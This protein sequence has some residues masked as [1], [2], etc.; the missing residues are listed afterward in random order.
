M[1]RLAKGIVA[2]RWLIV[3]LFLAMIV[4]SVF[5]L[6]WVHVEED[7][8]AYLPVDAEAKVGLTI[9]E[10]EFTT[11]G[12]AKV[13]VE[14]L[15]L[16]EAQAL[17]EQIGA[18]DNVVLVQFDTTEN[19]FHDNTALYDL[20]FSDVAMAESSITALNEVKALLE[21]RE[22]TVYSDVGFSLAAAVAGQMASVLVF[23]VIVVFAVLIFT[24]TTYAEIPLMII[25]FVVAAAINL[26][27]HFLLGTI[28]FVSNS[29]AIVLQLALSVDYAIIL[30][31]RFKEEHQTLGIRESVEKALAASI[32]EIFASSLTTIAGLTAM[33]FM[34]FRL[35]LDLGLGLI[36]AIFCS[37]FTVFLFMPSMLMLFGK[38]IDKTKHKSFVPKI[39]FVGKFAYATRFIM[40][41]LFVALVAGSYMIFSRTE[42]VYAQDM[43]PAHRMTER[44]TSNARIREAFGTSNLVALIV[45]AGDYTSEQALTQELSEYPEVKSATGLASFEIA[46]G[47]RL[48]DAVT[49]KELSELADVDETAAEAVFAFYAANAG[50]HRAALE[51]LESYRAPLVDVFLFLYKQ[52]QNGNAD[53]LNEDQIQMIEDLYGQLSLLSVQLQSDTYSRIVLDLNLPTQSDETFAFLDKIHQVAAPYYGDQVVLTGEPVSALGFKDSFASDNRVVSLMSLVLGLII[54][55]FTFRSFGMPLLLNLVIQG[56]IWMNFAIATLQGT[57]IFFLCYLIVSSIQ[58]GANIDYAIVVSSRYQE[59]RETMERREAIIATLNVAFPTIITSGLMMVCAGLLIGFRVSTTIIAGMGYYVGTGTSISLLLILFALPQVLVF[60]DRFVSATTL[61]SKE[62]PGFFARHRRAFAAVLLVLALVF[63]SGT[64]YYAMSGTGSTV[65][66]IETHSVEKIAEIEALRPLAQRVEDAHAELDSLSYAFAEQLMTDK[67]GTVRL[68]EGEEQY[69]EGLETYNEGKAQYDEGKAQLE[70]AE[71]AYDTGAQ[72]LAEGQAVYDSSM[73]QF[74]AGQAALAEGSAQLAAGQAEYDA[75]LAQ[76]NEGK[77]AYEAGQAE[78]AAGQAE[79]DAGLERYNQ[80]KAALDAVTPL[81]EA[82]LAVQA[83]V[84]ELEAAYNQAVESGDTATAIALEATLN[85]ARAAAIA[86]DFYGLMAQYQAAQAELAAG[87]AELAAGKAKLD[88]GYAQLAEAEAQL[89]EAEAQLA[90]GKAKLDEGY[91]AQAAGQA[92]LNDAAG[93]LAAGKARLD[94]GYAELDEGGAQIEEGRAQLEDA[95]EQLKEGKAKL[96]EGEAE[97]KE[98]RETLKQNREDLE[99]SLTTLD[100]ISEDEAALEEA[101]D[102]L[103]AEPELSG[104]L[105]RNAGAVETLDASVAYYRNAADSAQE[106]Q[107]LSQKLLIALAVAAVLALVGLLL[108]IKWLRFPSVLLTLAALVAAAAAIVWYGRCPALSPYVFPAALVFA[109]VTA[110]NAIA[111]RHSANEKEEEME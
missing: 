102:K 111:M 96:D 41:I 49:C 70:E 28:S 71:K 98:G 39:S 97:L 55:F 42:Y 43:V 47:L 32:P 101:L 86:T 93:M 20:T 15:S 83:R 31:N 75:G 11:L 21:G 89:A 3:A 4:F 99:D 16:E 25:V 104:V 65:D 60:G 62:G 7:V 88:A 56:S 14:N 66:A 57:P 53:Q 23:V 52:I 61:P 54:L 29:V 8:T 27:T 74:Y 67:I 30:C 35:G 1:T 26:G 76:Y 17:S 108:S 77:A 46:D 36:K 37:L 69:K 110:Y 109:I 78:L 82:A 92:Q 68:E 34:K 9:M 94:A 84:Q 72:Q 50:D 58:M 63:S 73:Q 79:Y 85:A 2:Q 51:D 5:S 12:T 40:P 90:A 106:Q 87:E 44:E 38:A 33:T 24:S 59:F 18:V 19:H 105:R 6:R 80:G 107:Q 13:M 45:P 10:E 95:E 81:Y 22:V 100:S 48:G 91:A 64:A 103:R